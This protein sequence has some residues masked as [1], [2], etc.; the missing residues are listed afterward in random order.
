MWVKSMR[1]KGILAVMEAV[2]REVARLRRWLKK[3][4]GGCGIGGGQGGE[5]VVEEGYDRR[6]QVKRKHVN[7][8][9]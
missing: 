9:V 3:K 4:E 1:R 8:K 5:M 7:K 6:E 2:M